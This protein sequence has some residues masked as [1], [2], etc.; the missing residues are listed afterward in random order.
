VFGNQKGEPFSGVEAVDAR[1]A[2]G[3]GVRGLGLVTWHPWRHI[4]SSL[5]ND[6][7]VPAKIAREQPGDASVSTSRDFGP[8]FPRLAFRRFFLWQRVR[9]RSDSALGPDGRPFSDR[10]V[11]LIPQNSCRE[12]MSAV[13]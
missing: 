7:R 2:A 4:H 5:L 11:A 6:L 8:W 12:W 3:S 13:D 1:A 10:W 9:S